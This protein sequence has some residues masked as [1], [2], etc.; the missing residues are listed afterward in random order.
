[1]TQIQFDSDPTRQAEAQ[2]YITEWLA[3]RA[4][5]DN[6]DNRVDVGTEPKP[7]GT[8]SV[9]EQQ[10]LQSTYHDLRFLYF[11]SFRG[12]GDTPQQAVT[13]RA[14][15]LNLPFIPDF[16]PAWDQ[17]REREERGLKQR[18]TQLPTEVVKE[19]WYPTDSI[20]FQTWA[21]VLIE[22][23]ESDRQ[24][25][26]RRWPDTLKTAQELA[27]P[28]KPPTMSL[29]DDWQIA[30]VYRELIKSFAQRSLGVHQRLSEDTHTECDLTSFGLKGGQTLLVKLAD[31]CVECVGR[32]HIGPPDTPVMPIKALRERSD[33]EKAAEFDL[34]HAVDRTG[35][36]V[37][38]ASTK[39][40]DVL[41]SEG[42]GEAEVIRAFLQLL[43]SAFDCELC[44]FL[45]VE[46]E[47]AAVVWRIATVRGS[48]VPRE[49]RDELSA[50]MRE[51][52]RYNKGEGIS[53]S[54]LLQQYGDR[55]VWYHTGSNDVRGDPRSSTLHVSAYEKHLY[56]AVL[57]TKRIENFWMFPIFDQGPPGET[58][59]L[60]GAFRVVNRIGK[61]D[62]NG[63]VHLQAGGWPYVERVQ[64]AL[65]AD[66]FS[67]FLSTINRYP[68][69]TEDFRG[70]VN[71]E[72][73]LRDLLWEL[74]EGGVSW[75]LPNNKA[76]WS[77]SHT[78]VYNLLRFLTRLSEAKNEHRHLGCTIFLGKPKIGA[79][80]LE[81]LKPHP[82]VEVTLGRQTATRAPKPASASL[83]ALADLSWMDL[84]SDA[85]DPAQDAFVF[86][87][88][89]V[90]SR[91][92]VF[93]QDGTR[94]EEAACF[95]TK[96]DKS[97]ICLMLERGTKS[98]LVIAKGE[99]KA[100]IRL[101]EKKGEWRFRSGDDIA[102]MMSRV[103]PKDVADEVLQV[104]TATALILSRRGEGA[105]L[106]IGTHGSD[107]TWEDKG[108]MVG[109]N[110]KVQDLK[111]EAIAECAKL[112]GATF[113]DADGTVKA[114]NRNVKVKLDILL[115]PYFQGRGLRH[116]TAFK[117]AAASPEAL[118][119]VVSQNGGICIVGPRGEKAEVDL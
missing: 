59:H 69:R 13:N 81:A 84:Y 78:I 39:L 109:S 25:A 68:H 99:R 18:F 79:L 32:S 14:R 16:F 103:R 67:G 95:V 102:E 66:W 117:I 118:V 12:V 30:S 115:P 42:F 111:P 110:S 53:G 11:K 48:E 100:E 91:I 21:D 33:L 9:D 104:A 56:P 46:D 60:K 5:K 27:G 22:E 7:I 97:A 75:L 116:E 47:G 93:A 98:V 41:Y 96:N 74:R 35:E 19:T 119:V 80:P 83:S 52:E 55:T 89:G 50:P 73:E 113:I 90:F 15:Q 58:P 34:L 20:A 92:V 76:S 70:I 65:V 28:G 106:V 94:G 17:A 82:L 64:L 72:G 4:K 38:Q 101:A 44:D 40:L 62:S 87:E 114:F 57:S 63:T 29:K 108:R 112:D 31:A 26:L 86:C 24:A 85:T 51:A 36:F 77:Q 107:V 88:T 49:Q 45:E 2:Q 37:K 1:M 23:M 8:L 54:I 10:Q 43:Q 6:L 71:M 105:I 3:E 61:T